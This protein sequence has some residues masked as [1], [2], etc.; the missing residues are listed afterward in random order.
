[1]TGAPTA[2]FTVHG[3]RFISGGPPANSPSTV[4]S[5]SGAAS[6]GGAVAD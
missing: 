4:C 5:S 2:T 1:M 3:S 6:P